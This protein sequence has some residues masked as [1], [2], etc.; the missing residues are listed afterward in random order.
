M[1]TDYLGDVAVERETGSGI[2]ILEEEETMSQTEKY[3]IPDEGEEKLLEESELDLGAEMPLSI[4]KPK[5]GE[6]FTLNPASHFP[7]PML[8]WK[9]DPDGIDESLFY[10]DPKLRGAIIQELRKVRF[11]ICNSVR[12][13]AFFIWAV[14]VSDTNW[15]RSLEALLNQPKDFFRNNSIRIRSDKERGRY[16]AFSQ[17]ESRTVNWP[18]KPI[19]HGL[20]RL[21][22]WEKDEIRQKILHLRFNSD[23]NYEMDEIVEYCM[24]DCRACAA[25]FQHQR[26]ASENHSKLER[27]MSWLPIYLRAVA[28]MEL[29]GIPFDAPTYHA[30][31]ANQGEIRARL[32][33]E[34]NAVAP[35]MNPSGINRDAF[36]KFCITNHI[37]LP[38]MYDRVSHK[39]RFSVENETLKG[40]EHHHPLIPKIRE[41]QKTLVSLRNSK[42]I[43][44]FNTRRHYFNVIP[45]GTITGRN[46]PRQFIFNMAKWMRFLVVPESPEHVLVYVD[47]SAQEIGIVAALSRDPAMMEMYQADDPHMAFAELSGAVPAGSRKEDCPE[48]RR[49]Y[50]TVKLGVLYGLTPSGTARKLGISEREAQE[51]H[52]EHQKL[53]PVFW[54]WSER[55]VVTAMHRGSIRTRL[56]WRCWVPSESNERTWANWPMQA[57]GAEIMRLTIMYM[58]RRGLTLLAPI[59]D[60]FLLSCR[61]DAIDDMKEELNFACSTSVE[62]ALP[63]F[64]LRWTV[65]IYE[66]RFEDPD[67]LALWETIKRLIKDM[68]V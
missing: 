30:I 55:R 43:V 19:R 42:M 36:K 44:D 64:K 40:I 27:L 68:T 63:N 31:I 5:R 47:Y 52:K 17:P 39:M 38:R 60:G 18:T 58:E 9:P 1:K 46:A 28:K 35:V 48:I 33:G 7:I 34:I 49:K 57:S 65:E 16:L 62:H 11:F 2:G 41:T 25:L 56:G 51:L 23:N 59:H 13:N 37:P 6:F 32:A 14:K 50:K 15:Y 61:R 45:F 3:I 29:R 10:V 67:G 66:E 8:C 12:S 26:I 54:N 4:R 24:Q 20:S 53:F 22:P 21:I